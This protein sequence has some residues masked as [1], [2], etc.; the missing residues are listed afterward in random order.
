MRGRR[1]KMT[2][3]PSFTT[4]RIK[5]CSTSHAQRLITRRGKGDTVAHGLGIS[6]RAGG[7][8]A[9]ARSAT[10]RSPTS[11]SSHRTRATST[12][13]QEAVS[14]H[15]STPGTKHILRRLPASRT[16]LVY[17]SIEQQETALS[18]IYEW[19]RVNTWRKNGTSHGDAH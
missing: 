6:A 12:D 17:L 16:R 14:R 7:Q 1:D 11:S 5:K 13:W 9:V 2:I 18:K 3:V 4:L 10:R 15:Y 8:L 19:G